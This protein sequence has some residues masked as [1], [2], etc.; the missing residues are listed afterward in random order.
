METFVV[1]IWV[2]AE[3]YAG[4][5]PLRGFVEDVHGGRRVQ[6]GSGDE[7]VA[8]FAERIATRDGTSGSAK[9]SAT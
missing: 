8:F 3:P 5:K 2:P 4:R 6:F 1:R 7:L 9:R